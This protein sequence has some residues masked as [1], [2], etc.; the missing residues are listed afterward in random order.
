[1]K[2]DE[3]IRF[4]LELDPELSATLDRDLG[5]AGWSVLATF[6]RAMLSAQLLEFSVF[7]LA[8]LD[9]KTPKAWERA[10]AQIE[11]LLKQPKGDQAKGLAGVDSDLSEDL[12]TAIGARNK[13]A[14]DG[15]LNYRIDAA[16]RGEPAHEEARAMYRAIALFLDDVRGRLD[17]IAET[18]LN[19]LGGDELDDED[20]DAIFDSLQNWASQATF[21]ED[22]DVGPH[23]PAA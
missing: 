20:M 9:R 3:Q 18:R 13:L 8:H 16:I 15:L 6:G 14:H 7:Q 5:E 2:R 17:A 4:V 12:K 21:S 11:G 1:M 22:V 23:E 10:L 19:D